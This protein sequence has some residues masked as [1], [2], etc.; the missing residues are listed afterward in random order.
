MHTIILRT[1]TIAGLTI[2]ASTIAMASP[3]RPPLNRDAAV[4][5]SQVERVYY[6]YNH[7]RYRHRSWDK[8][9]RRWRYGCD[10]RYS[11]KFE[12][13]NTGGS[14]L[15]D[16]NAMRAKGADVGLETAPVEAQRTQQS[17]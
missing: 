13:R 12:H 2:G 9:H 4:Q 3:A 1:L 11:G 17:S 16:S 7:H 8:R 5:T 15:V 10:H 14:Q 6:Y